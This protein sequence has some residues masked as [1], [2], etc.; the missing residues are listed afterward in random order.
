M[1]KS[2]NKAFLLGNLTRDPELKQSEGKKPLCVFGL[3]TN[4][5]WQQRP[6]KSGRRPSSIGLL[7]GISSPRRVSGISKRAE[8]SMLRG[9]YKLVPIPGKT[10]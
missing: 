8:R 1:S 3:A 2:I 7:P 4:R 9:D 10:V 6:E 5:S